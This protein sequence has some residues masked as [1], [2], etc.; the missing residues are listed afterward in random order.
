MALHWPSVNTNWPKSS[1]LL[2][3]FSQHQLCFTIQ[4]KW[5]AQWYTTS[6]AA[7]V[8]DGPLY[9]TVQFLIINLVLQGIRVGH[10]P[11]YVIHPY[12]SAHACKPSGKTIL[13]IQV[14]THSWLKRG[15]PGGTKGCWCGRQLVVA[16]FLWSSRTKVVHKHSPNSPFNV[17]PNPPGT[18]ISGLRRGFELGSFAQGSGNLTSH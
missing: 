5:L 2:L 13:V 16:S 10:S 14:C 9:P 8:W 6:G 4:L 15:G 3:H 7:H 1:W 11:L 17:K 12:L 18:A